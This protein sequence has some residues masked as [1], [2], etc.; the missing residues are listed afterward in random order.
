MVKNPIV[1]IGILVRKPVVAAGCG[2]AMLLAFSLFGGVIL[3]PQFQQLL[4]NFTATLSGL[5]I[6]M[7]RARA[8][9]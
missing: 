9:W 3:A 7:P 5:S 2:L 6:L 4:L 8:S 1:D